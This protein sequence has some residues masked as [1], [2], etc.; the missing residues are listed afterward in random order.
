[1]QT[2]SEQQTR[3]RVERLR[4]LM[5]QT[6]RAPIGAFVMVPTLTA[7]VA[8]FAHGPGPY[9]WALVAFLVIATRA[10]FAMW[11]LRTDH[12]PPTEWTECAMIVSATLSG[13]MAGLYALLFA[14]TLPP[15]EQGVITAAIMGWAAASI[16]TMSQLPRQ[17]VGFLG[18]LATL[19]SISWLRSDS[20]HSVPVVVLIVLFTF[21][22]AASAAD[23]GKVIRD[24]ARMRFENVDLIA[25]LSAETEA[26]QNARALAEEAMLAK[27]RFLAATSHDLRQPVTA[28]SVLTGA[29]LQRPLEPSIRSVV[30]RIDSAV[31]SIDALLGGLLD[32]SRLD[33]K[34]IEPTLAPFDLD[35]LCA[36]L[37]DEFR[38]IADNKNLRFDVDAKVGIVISDPVLV[39]RIIRNLL[40]NALRYTL[41]GSVRLQARRDDSTFAIDVIDTGIGIPPD[42]QAR[43]FEEYFQVTNPGRQRNLGL[44]LGL[45]I[46]ERLCALLGARIEL[47]STPGKGSTFRVVHP[48]RS[49]PAYR[50]LP[51]AP[52][53]T[54]DAQIP[55]GS[56]VVVVDDDAG[57]QDGLTALLE[58]WGCRVVSGS[59]PEEAFEQAVLQRL[60]R[61]DCLLTDY[62][63]GAAQTGFDVPAH[64]PTTLAPGA[65]IVM[66]G[67]IDAAV[68]TEA[69]ARGFQFLD[70]PL[71][72]DTLKKAV[73]AAITTARA[74]PAAEPLEVRGPA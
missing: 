50:S 2:H 56:V 16:A 7:F 33:A 62:R 22:L 52:A 3:I 1:M 36:R 72:P 40:Q 19:L 61:I 12:P 48:I 8:P 67:D 17:Y 13:M 27:S 60:T 49:S 32:L 65:V 26:A 15:L 42:L 11:W 14:P 9:V 57:V 74:A 47:T 73:A 24:A 53:A 55:A 25:R 23:Y 29:L 46:V 68:R 18:A 44:G 59:T 51:T 69:L 31:E 37:S 58:G 5:L 38:P 30:S 10:T 54:A 41:T 28:L 64:A 34:A 35:H 66:T 39:E 4:L 71:R 43:V 20:S 63:L 6:R 21:I 45:S 70:K